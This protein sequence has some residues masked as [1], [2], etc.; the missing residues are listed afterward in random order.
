MI[1]RHRDLDP[2][3]AAIP[4]ATRRL[5]EGADEFGNLLDFQLVWNVP[6]HT[7]G[8]LRRRQKDVRLLAVGLRTAP[9]VRELGEHETPVVMDSVGYRAVR[10]DDGVVVIGDLLP[11]GGRRRG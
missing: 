11:R 4:A 7:L 9:E 5:A 3:E 10:R 8:N 2:I 1:V 6:M